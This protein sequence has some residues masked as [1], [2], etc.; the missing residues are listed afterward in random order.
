MV[1]G[2]SILGTGA[3]G[4]TPG[5][6]ASKPRTVV[7]STP[8]RPVSP[9]PV[10][11]PLLSEVQVKQSDDERL[12]LD[13]VVG[14]VRDRAAVHGK[15][16]AHVDW[17]LAR[18]LTADII[19]EVRPKTLIGVQSINKAFGPTVWVRIN[20]IAYRV[21]HLDGARRVMVELWFAHAQGNATTSEAMFG[22]FAGE[23]VQRGGQWRISSFAD[24]WLSTVTVKPPGGA[25]TNAFTLLD[26][27]ASPELNDVKPA[28]ALNAQPKRTTS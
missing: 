8:G 11:R 16:A 14:F 23:L 27:I 15:D 1:G 24:T 21:T 20:P 19:A 6:A 3:V 13:T 22:T 10:T 17:L 7:P 28:T 9:K 25:N 4:A 2:L 5:A 26:G 12:Q 18:W